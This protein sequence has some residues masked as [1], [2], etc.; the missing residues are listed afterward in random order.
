MTAKI[1][2]SFVAVLLLIGALNSRAQST[3][4]APSPEAQFRQ[5]VQ[6][7]QMKAK[8]GE[9]TEADY[10]DEIKTFDRLIAATKGTNNEL[11]AK[12]EYMKSILY[13]E[14]LNNEDKAAEILHQ[15]VAD[16]PAT[17]IAQ[18]AQNAVHVMD[19]KKIQET[20]APATVFPD[21]SVK[22]TD[23]KPLSVSAFKG[24]VVLLDFW[25]TWCPNCVQQ[26]PNVMALYQKHHKDGFEII[27]V[28]MDSE[29]AALAAY[30][31]KAGGMTWPQYFDGGRWTN[32]LAVKYGVT[33]IPFTVLIGPDGRIIGK[34]LAGRELEYS[35][36]ATLPKK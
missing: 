35:L 20:L 28:N 15:L 24:K 7:I 4:A 1:V 11:A 22:D 14:L 31:K 17:T 26:M 13:V 32:A 2:S 36:L 19:A 21:F 6:G 18:E 10:A 8:S 30:L 25:A 23:G 16:F 29:P 3:N 34:N 5:L 27:G 33:A 12:I 9:N